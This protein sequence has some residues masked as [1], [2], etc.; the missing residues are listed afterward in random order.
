LRFNP[1][2]ANPFARVPLSDWT[3]A[4]DYEITAAVP[5]GG[6]LLAFGTTRHGVVFVST[7][8]GVLRRI[9]TG[10]GLLDAHVYSVFYDHRG[11]LW[12]ALDNGIALIG[13]SLQPDA[14]AVPFHAL[15][16]GVTGTRDDKILFG[17]TYSDRRGGVASLKQPDFLR[18]EFPFKYN[19]FR[20]AFSAN[21]IQSTGDMQFRTLMNGV[22]TKWS[23]WSTRFE[24]EFT[25]LRPG[26]WNFRVQ[27]RKPNGELSAEAT[28]QLIILKA[29]Y[30]T[31]WFTLVQVSV[32]LALLVLPRYARAIKGLQGGL[33]NFSVI[34]PFS[35]ISAAMSSTIGHYSAGVVFF[36]VLM[37]STLS[38]ILDPAKKTLK[39][40]VETR[41]K[42]QTA[43]EAAVKAKM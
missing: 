11:G 18:P 9:G 29:W 6:D 34:V 16:R 24:R 8:R 15:I 1:A 5:L 22:D 43:S 42:R 25:E 35:Y 12:A 4:D 19:A 20:F 31:L 14:A 26:T 28:Y 33:I 2:A 30:D 41:S 40:Q 27:A 21:G 13:L 23:N 39:K 3:A 17:G 38:F 10:E 32:V 36:K 37:S 7:S